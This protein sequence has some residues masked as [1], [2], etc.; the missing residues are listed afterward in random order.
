MVQAR[1]G[2]FWVLWCMVQVQ[3]S[4]EI[5]SAAVSSGRVMLCTLFMRHLHRIQS[6]GFPWRQGVLH[7]GF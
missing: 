5:K 3:E 1:L 7:A 4:I 6:L 2:C